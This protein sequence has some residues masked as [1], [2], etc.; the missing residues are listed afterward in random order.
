VLSSGAA[1]FIYSTANAMTALQKEPACTESEYVIAET[2]NSVYGSL[3]ALSSTTFTQTF[4]VVAD[5]SA[6]IREP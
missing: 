2:G 4:G 3:P 6:M 1:N 5:A